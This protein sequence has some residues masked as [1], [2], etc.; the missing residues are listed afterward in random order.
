MKDAETSANIIFNEE[1]QMSLRKALDHAKESMR[2]IMDTLQ[3]KGRTIDSAIS[4]VIPTEEVTQ[5]HAAL[6]LMENGGRFIISSIPRSTL[7]D[8]N[9]NYRV[10]E[11]GLGKSSTLRHTN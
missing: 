6:P 8:N 10:Q 7:P 5:L 3:S 1:E 9:L 11:C 4:N 2:L